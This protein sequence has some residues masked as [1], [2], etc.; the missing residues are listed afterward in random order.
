[1]P[2]PRPQP[3][4]AARLLVRGV[5]RMQ[6]P[7]MQKIILFAALTATVGLTVYAY[8]TGDKH[9][10]FS[11]KGPV[12]LADRDGPVPTGLDKLKVATRPDLVSAQPRVSASELQVVLPAPRVMDSVRQEINT[13]PV[14]PA[15]P[16]QPITADRT[17]ANTIDK[18]AAR[19]PAT[20]P[21]T[22]PAPVQ[23]A[24][25]AI[26]ASTPAPAPSPGSAA[27]R[28]SIAGSPAAS[29]EASATAKDAPASVSAATEEG[30]SKPAPERKR[31][32][33]REAP[34]HSRPAAS[35]PAVARYAH[36]PSVF[37]RNDGM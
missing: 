7:T 17:D 8:P 10:A 13:R 1:M 22:K 30:R 33:R 29:G 18:L 23:P 37:K 9:A 12:S 19:L 3:M 31:I 14:Q 32:V 25:V 34:A 6:R 36:V 2:V 16:P 35:A 27:P 15:P 20:P 11:L 28:S 4:R 26:P 21:A 24:S 5:H